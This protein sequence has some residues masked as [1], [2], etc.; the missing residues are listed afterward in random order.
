MSA[1]TVANISTS[2]DEYEFTPTQDWFTSNILSWKSLFPLVTSS[3]PRILEIGSWEGRSAVFLLTTLCAQ[4]G[5]IVCVDHFDLEQTPAGRERHRKLKDNLARTGRPSRILPQFSVPAL[6]KLLEEEIARGAG[7]GFDWVYVDGSHRADDTLLDA[8]L[9]WRL[10]REG[11]IFIFDDYNWPEQPVESIHHPR[12]GIDAFLALHAG[13]YEQLSTSPKQYQMILKKTS[14]M[15]IGF[16]IEKST[17]QLTRALGY[18]IYIVLAVD[19]SYAIPVAVT[20]RSAIEKTAG[21]ITIYVV[22]CG[23]R[24]ED[25]EKIKASLP[26]RHDI[27]L[28]FLD[29]PARSLATELGT[30]WAKIDMLKILPVQRV[31]YLD[32]DMLVRRSLEELWSTDLEGAS[33]AAAVD[34]AFPMGHDGIPRGRYFNAGMLLIDLARARVRL[35]ELEARVHEMKDAR[36]R[37]QDALN[38]HFAGDWAEGLGTY[39]ETCSVDRD[40]VASEDM[41]DPGLVHFTGPVHPDLAAVLNPWVQPYT[42]KPWGYAGAPGHPFNNQWWSMLKKTAWAEWQGSTQYREMCEGEQK[43]AIQDAIAEFKTRVHHHESDCGQ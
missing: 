34:V 29:L 42:A 6:Y 4:G 32:A 10:A 13:E 39:A 17:H 5:E 36:F 22:D 2:T 37:D 28:M 40:A 26:E 1:S 14:E 38:V 27:T 16:L 9:A 35:P 21:L 43:R 25:K 12:R 15:R 30:V 3:E 18:G 19:T 7:A 33:I 23:L 41:K 8:E 20:I 24:V 11:C 31:L